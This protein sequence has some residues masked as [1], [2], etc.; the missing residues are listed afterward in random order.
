MSTLE[1]R[2]QRIEDD[3]AIR[4]LVARFADPCTRGDLNA[5]SKLWVSHG[6]TKAIWT[7]TEPFPMSA[8]GIDDIVAMCDKLRTSRD[9]FVQL[10]HTG[11]VGVTG[12]RASGRWILREVAKGPGEVYYNN[13][14]MYEDLM[15]KHGGEWFF[16]KRD[17]NYMFLDSEPFS[18]KVFSGVG[19]LKLSL[20]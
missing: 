9:F 4:D 14:S 2:I 16:A 11:V 17:Y 15:E 5:F 13:F 19:S 1:E 20:G 3:M 18:G 10:V 12:D 8:T 7:L 6:D